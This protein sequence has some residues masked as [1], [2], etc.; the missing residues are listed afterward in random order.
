VDPRIFF[1][2]ITFDALATER[3]FGV[4]EF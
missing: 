4:H 3:H 2:Q 1:A